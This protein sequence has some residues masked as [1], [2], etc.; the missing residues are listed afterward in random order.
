MCAVDRWNRAHHVPL[1][2]ESATSRTSQGFEVR[3][4]NSFMARLDKFS[5][6]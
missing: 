6:E 1:L 4:M 3:I 5:I 2:I